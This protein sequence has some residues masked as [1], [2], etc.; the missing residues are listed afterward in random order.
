[1]SAPRPL[2]RLV[3]APIRFYQRFLSPWLPATCRFSPT[4]SQY[5]C[6]AVLAHGLWKGGRLTLWRVLRCQPFARGG[7]DPVPGTEEPG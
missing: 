1:M 5:A 3:V 4:C 6:E 7:L 2:R